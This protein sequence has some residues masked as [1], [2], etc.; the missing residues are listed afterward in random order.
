[1]LIELQ[2]CLR[3]IDCGHGC[4]CCTVALALALVEVV[5]KRCHTVGILLLLLLLKMVLVVL[6]I[7]DDDTYG[8]SCAGARAL[9]VIKRAPRRDLTRR[10]NELIRLF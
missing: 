3:V 7:G 9:V 8:H 4:A 10:D 1:M 5:I 2:S 6:A